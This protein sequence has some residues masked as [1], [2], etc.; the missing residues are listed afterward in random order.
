I[1]RR[2]VPKSNGAEH[3]VVRRVNDRHG[4]GEL[5]RRVEAVAMTYRDIWRVRGAWSLSRK[6]RNDTREQQREGETENH[7][8][9]SFGS[10]VS[11][12]SRGRQLSLCR[13]C[14]MQIAPH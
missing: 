10:L 14:V 1:S 12:C 11:S 4:V 5:V 2:R 3:L 8:F 6:R 13:G 7:W 9:S